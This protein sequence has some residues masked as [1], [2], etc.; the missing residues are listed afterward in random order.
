MADILVEISGDVII[1]CLNY[2]LAHQGRTNYGS[3][4]VR[5]R[6]ERYIDINDFL[7][8]KPN[9]NINVI[10]DEID[11]MVGVNSFNLV[12][13]DSEIKTIYNI[14]LMKEWKSVIGF[15]GTIS[16]S[17]VDQLRAELKNPICIDIPSLRTN[18]NSNKVVSVVKIKDYNQL[19]NKI[20]EKINDCGADNAN[21]IVIFD[22]KVTLHEF[23]RTSACV[24]PS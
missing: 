23:H 19:F 22:D 3:A 1:V 8:M 17:T 4:N 7:K 13:K 16:E 14:N 12:E 9:P 21:F 20:E 2:F 18:G 11:R 6:K 5:Y 10:F 15:S 24:I